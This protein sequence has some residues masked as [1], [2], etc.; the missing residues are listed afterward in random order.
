MILK[1]EELQAKKELENKKEADTTKENISITIEFK[2]E[3]SH[4][5][6]DPPVAS[7]DSLVIVLVEKQQSLMEN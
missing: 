6:V 5:F 2:Q 3:K 7:K 4:A 1:E